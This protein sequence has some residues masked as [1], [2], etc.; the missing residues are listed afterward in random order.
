MEGIVSST[1]YCIVSSPSEEAQG[2]GKDGFY[3]DVNRDNLR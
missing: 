1:R 3:A 2:G